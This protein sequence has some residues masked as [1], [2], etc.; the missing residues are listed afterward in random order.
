M[1]IFKL[2]YKNALRHKLRTAL[3]VLGMA[4]AVMAFGVL[5]TVVDMYY[6][7]IDASAVNR[8]ITRQAVSYIFPLPYSY[9]DKIAKVPGVETVSFAN[10]FGGT[11][12]D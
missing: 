6:A 2:I 7:G 3:T 5:R 9:R 11:Y 12:I 8:L 10:W 1:R 4:I